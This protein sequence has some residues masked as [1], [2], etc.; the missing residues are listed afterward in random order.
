MKTLTVAAIVL[1]FGITV[2]GQTEILTNAKI[3]GMTKAGLS[4]DIILVKI[5]TSVDRFDV[6]SDALIEMKKAGVADDVIT[7][8]VDI[9]RSGTS[10]GDAE[11]VNPN[12]GGQLSAS[13]NR[14]AIS[15]STASTI[16]IQKSSLNPSRQALEKELLKR[17]DWLSLNLTIEQ[18]KK[19]ADLYIDIGFVPLSLVTHRYV[20]R[21][22]DRRTG[23]VIA[24]G[25]TTSWGSLAEHLAKHICESLTKIRDSAKGG[26][27]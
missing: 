6:S 20:Y 1:I 4:S 7:A 8:V 12:G 17:S 23:A 15:L 13:D 5:K 18:Y 26:L 27:G 14:A 9:G 22:Y 19:D 24:A 10:R 11:S 16:A 2:Y 3:I 21:I 25:E